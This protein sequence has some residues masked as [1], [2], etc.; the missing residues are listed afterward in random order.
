MASAR[1]VSVGFLYLSFHLSRKGGH[2][3]K[4]LPAANLGLAAIELEERVPSL[5]PIIEESSLSSFFIVTD[6]HS[7]LRED[8]LSAIR[9]TLLSAANSAQIVAVRSH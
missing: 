7:L 6:T 3:M 2:H 1:G 4:A 5:F 8:L 9:G